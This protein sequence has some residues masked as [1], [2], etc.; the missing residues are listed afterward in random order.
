MIPFTKMQGNGNDFIVIDNRSGRFSEKELSRTAISFCRRRR[1]L[2]ADGILAV[3]KASDADYAMRLFNADGS[4]GEMC[5]NGARCIAR[6]A[7]EKKIAG[8]EQEISTRA[9]IMKAEVDSPFVDLD[10]GRISLSQGWFNRTVSVLEETFT[11]SFL[12]VG[13]PHAVLF[14]LEDLSSERMFLVGRE[15]RHDLSL[16]PEGANVNFVVPEDDGR[17]RSVTYERGVE[18][19]TDSCGTGSTASAICHLLRDSFRREEKTVL[20]VINP[21]G[22]NAVTLTFDSG[23]NWVHASLRGRTVIVAEGFLTGEL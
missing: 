14:P 22:I 12:Q 3:E 9:G 7:Y 20:D 23:G 19:L 11:A 5:G 15:L 1:S 4:E 21:G 8:R 13:V 16:F 17:I 18:D 2:G 10:M 6:Y